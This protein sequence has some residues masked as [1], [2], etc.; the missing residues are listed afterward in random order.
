L[1]TTREISNLKYRI[2]EYKPSKILYVV[3]NE[4]S[5]HFSQLFAI[6]KLLNLG[7]KIE[8]S[9]VKHGMVSE[10]DGKK[11][12]TREGRTI[13][14]EELLSRAIE[15]SEKT[16][17]DRSS[18]FKKGEMKDIAKTIAI[19]AVKY[20]D[21]S[22]NRLSDISFDWDKMLSF[23]GNSAPY[24]QYTYARLKSILRKAGRIPNKKIITLEN[25]QD[26]SLALKLLEFPQALE[27]TLE[28][29][30][31]NYLA[32]YLYELAKEINSFYHS[33]PVLYADPDIRLA[34][35]NLVKASA[36]TLKTGLKLLGV[37]T[38]EKM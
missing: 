18:N 27:Q 28:F 36:R 7:E 24:L 23:E 37:D 26:Q 30:L 29:Y 5:L 34:R 4:Q 12:S 10:G 25:E 6:A 17:K 14:L 33:E 20:N 19:G 9:H 35:L 11:L 3:G 38:V 31:P 1:Y 15:L 8:L 13:R 21:L 32:T 16:L 2:E 22:Q